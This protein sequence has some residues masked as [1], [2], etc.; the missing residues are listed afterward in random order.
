[1]AAG[2]YMAAAGTVT[3]IVGTILAGEAAEKKRAE[4]KKIANTPG[5][6]FGSVTGGALAD[7]MKYLP[8]G[9]AVAERI[10]QIN[11]ANLM[12]REEASLPGV[13]A[14]REKALGGVMGLFDDKAWLA[15]TMRTGAAMGAT[16]GLMGT[17]AGQMTSIYQGAKDKMARLSLGTGLLSQIIGSMRV[18][19]TSPSVTAFLSPTPAQAIAIRG[20]ERTQRMNILLRRAGMPTRLS[21]YGQSLQEYGGAMTG[22]GYTMMG[23]EASKPKVKPPPEGDDWGNEK[24]V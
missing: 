23:D 19:T 1:M 21:T 7:L 15:D 5:L 10:S 24:K 11:Q 9:S 3:D 2:G 13:G 18:D 12:A 14:A 4:V 17:G 6:D 8:Q 16:R 22:A 20:D